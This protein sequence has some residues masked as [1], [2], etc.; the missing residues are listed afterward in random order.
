[1]TQTPL[2]PSKKPVLSSSWESDVQFLG[3][4][5]TEENHSSYP[6]TDEVGVGESFGGFSVS[7][8]LWIGGKVRIAAYLAWYLLGDMELLSSI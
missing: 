6:L 1:M 4:L 7:P 2:C 3:W 5:E 8:V